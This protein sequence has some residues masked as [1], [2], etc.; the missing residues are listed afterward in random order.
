VSLGVLRRRPVSNPWFTRPWVVIAAAAFIGVPGVLLG[1]GVVGLALANPVTWFVAGAVWFALGFRHYKH[2]L[3]IRDTPLSKIDSAAIGLV[4]I[5]GRVQSTASQ[6]APV[7]GEPCI[8]WRISYK[9]HRDN[10]QENRI[11]CLRL[12]GPSSLPDPHLNLL[13]SNH[14]DFNSNLTIHYPS[15]TIRSDPICEIIFAPSLSVNRIE[16]CGSWKVLPRSRWPRLIWT[17]TWIAGNNLRLR[18]RAS[19]EREVCG[20]SSARTRQDCNPFLL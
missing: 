4:E 18:R 13:L 3:T 8:Y 1:L 10:E 15:G 14:A 17:H 9:A 6:K 2:Q 16:S 20:S 5:S 12:F 7:S 19:L 11:G